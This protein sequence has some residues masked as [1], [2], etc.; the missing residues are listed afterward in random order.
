MLES[1]SNKMLLIGRNS[2][3]KGGGKRHQIE[4]TYTKE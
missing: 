1:F 4:K 2:P 3:G